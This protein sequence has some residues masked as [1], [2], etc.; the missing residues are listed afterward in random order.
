VC[1]SRRSAFVI[2]T[3]I[4]GAI[5]LSGCASAQLGYNTLDLASSTNDLVTKQVLY[6]FAAFLDNPAAIPAQVTVSSG[7]T[8]TSN[9]LSP[10]LSL[11][12]STGVTTTRSLAGSQTVTLAD[13][14]GAKSL[15]VAAVDSWNQSWS[16]SPVT[17]PERMKRLQA[18][19]RYAVDWSEYGSQGDAYFVASFPPIQ[20]SI[21]ISAP[22]CIR[23]TNGKPVLFTLKDDTSLA[24]CATATTGT[25]STIPFTKGAITRSYSDQRDDPYYLTNPDCIVCGLLKHHRHVNPNIQ[26]PW[27]RWRNLTG[28]NPDPIRLPW[29]GDV[30]LGYA[31]HYQFFTSP[32]SAEK[33][34]NF[35]VA[36]LAAMGQGGSTSTATASTSSNAQA[37]NSKSV[38]LLD[39]LGNPFTLIVPGQ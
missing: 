13:V 38:T 30:S 31:G 11:P 15:S 39:N 21:G 4:V 23:A 24:F 9:S 20:R 3:L 2:A 33:F 16:F 8:T 25:T 19:Y 26:G 27:L 36:V 32:E 14:V 28:P 12:L 37:A 5:S 34:V 29:P 22:T 35:T 1:R 18:L 6:N 7:N 17:D 10:T